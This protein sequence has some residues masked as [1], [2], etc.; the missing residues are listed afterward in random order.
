M[1]TCHL[2]FITIMI[3]RFSGHDSSSLSGICVIQ[4]TKPEIQSLVRANSSHLLDS[5]TH[6]RSAKLWMCTI[7]P[8]M[9]TRPTLL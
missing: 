6:S 9:P 5:K 4:R 8:T 3:S 2:L 7:L 1:G